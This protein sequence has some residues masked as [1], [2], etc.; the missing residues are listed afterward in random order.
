MLLG[1]LQC[2]Q[3]VS[4]LLLHT[5]RLKGFNCLFFYYEISDATSMGPFLPT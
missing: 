5:D 1:I 2:Y 4:L 3:S